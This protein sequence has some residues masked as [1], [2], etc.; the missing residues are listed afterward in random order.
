MTDV[1]LLQAEHFSNP[2]RITKI[3]ASKAMADHEA[4]RLANTIRDDTDFKEMPPEATPEDWQ[5]LHEWLQDVH[6]AAHCYIDVS[7]IEIINQT[8]HVEIIWNDDQP[9]EGSYSTQIEALDAWEAETSVRAEMRDHD[10]YRRQFFTYGRLIECL[11]VQ[12][13]QET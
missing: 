11:E 3:F 12:H 10:A 6:G 13:G 1:Y 5:V 7:P 4:A 8:F 2:G 9:E